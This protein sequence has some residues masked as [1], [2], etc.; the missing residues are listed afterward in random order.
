MSCFIRKDVENLAAYHLDE[1]SGIKLNQNESPWD[2]PVTLKAQIVENLL[3]IS[4]N[5]YPLGESIQLRKKMAKQLGLWPDNILFANGSNV[6]I[7]ALLL[8]TSVGKK[9]LLPDPTFGVYE[10][11]AQLL[12]NTVVRVSLDEENFS[13]PVEKFVAAIKKEKPSIIF[14]PNP[15]AP[16]GNLLEVEALKKIIQAASCPVVID[17]AYYPFSG[18]TLIDMVRDYDNLVI[19]R[20]FS[21]AMALGGLR[22]G[23]LVAEPEM[24]MQVQKCLLPFCINRI[25]LVT[26]LTVLDDQE[27]V[28]EYVKKI[29][30]ERGRVFGEMQKVA[31]IKVYPSAA[32]FILFEVEKPNDVFKKLLE[33]GVIVRQV[34]D[35]RRLKNCLRVSIGTKEEN[36]SFLKSLRK[37]FV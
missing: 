9:V 35:G 37:V 1:H 26:A 33:L 10:Y 32:N 15:N 23:Y 19:L 11:Q 29:V 4:W 25:A 8:A 21:K 14:I 20:T 3:K 16:T 13:L 18:T 27:Y 28:D 17:E 6:L 30:A 22:L 24:V 36:E 7:Q 34:S 2:I 31:Q 5:R 12:G